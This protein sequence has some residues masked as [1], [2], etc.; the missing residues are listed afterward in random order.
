MLVISSCSVSTWISKHHASGTLGAG[1]GLL[2]AR[3]DA[4]EK[5]RAILRLFNSLDLV[6]DRRLADMLDLGGGERPAGLI[7]ADLGVV[8]CEVF[9]V[10]MRGAILERVTREDLAL[11]FS[12]SSSSSKVRLRFGALGSMFSESMYMAFLELF[13]PLMEMTMWGLVSSW[14]SWGPWRLTDCVDF[15][16]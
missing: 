16:D 11:T 6:M 13:I 5:G 8:D 7:G 2:R 15:D 3:A 14:D 10:E 9:G 1:L 4:R 12:F